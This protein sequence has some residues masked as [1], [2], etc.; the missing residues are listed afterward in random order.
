MS[1]W[2]VSLQVEL[3]SETGMQGRAEWNV[4][5][6]C[7]NPEKHNCSLGCVFFIPPADAGTKS[8]FVCAG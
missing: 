7:V 1:N 4:H 6:V 8:P 3:A 5:H 2:V